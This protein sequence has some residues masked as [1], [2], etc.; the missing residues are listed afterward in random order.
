VASATSLSRS[1]IMMLEKSTSC[2]QLAEQME[3]RWQSQ[4]T[5]DDS[6][7]FRM[8]RRIIRMIFRGL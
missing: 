1:A 8:P 6:S 2:G 4:S 3:Q 5:F 7:S